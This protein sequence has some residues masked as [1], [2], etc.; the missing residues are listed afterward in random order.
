MEDSDKGMQNQIHQTANYLR[1][2]VDNNY[3]YAIVSLDTYLPVDQG[4]APV[5]LPWDCGVGNT[6]SSTFVGDGEDRQFGVNQMSVR[7]LQYA[8]VNLDYNSLVGLNYVGVTHQV[9]KGF[10]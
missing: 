8:V 6:F 3:N 7:T 2:V 4:T 5:C 1:S 9:K 10:E